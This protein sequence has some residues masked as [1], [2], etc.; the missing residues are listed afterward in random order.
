[1]DEH[2]SLRF[3]DIRKKKQCSRQ[4]Q[5]GR[6]DRRIG[7]QS[8]NSIPPPPTTKKVCRCVCVGGGCGSIKIPSAHK[9]GQTSIELQRGFD[10]VG[11]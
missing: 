11:V 5:D 3:Q 9:Q 10:C 2:P 1:M 6:T 4:K 8:K 7:Q